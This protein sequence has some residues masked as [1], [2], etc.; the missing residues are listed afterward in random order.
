MDCETSSYNYNSSPIKATTNT[1]LYV[2]KAIPCLGICTNTRLTTVQ[3][4]IAEKLCEVVG[5]IDMSTVTIPT[6]LV[7]AW[8]NE[9]ETILN[10]FNF[11]LSQHCALSS[12]VDNIANGSTQIENFDPSF[13]VDYGCCLTDCITSTN[14]KL[15]EHIENIITCLCQTKTDLTLL[16]TDLETKYATL[17]TTTSLQGQIDDIKS[18]INIFNNNNPTNKIPI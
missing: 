14:L 11:L 4:A 1:V 5:D 17:V 2:G 18:G 3:V 15:S 8:G 9:D 12:Q 7:D 10:L 16:R 13:I 6:C